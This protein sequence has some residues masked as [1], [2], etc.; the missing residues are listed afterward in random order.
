MGFREINGDYIIMMGRM[1]RLW[2]RIFRN[3]LRTPEERDAPKPEALLKEGGK[4]F[5]AANGWKSIRLIEM[6]RIKGD[7]LI[8]RDIQSAW[9]DKIV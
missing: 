7:Q 9:D 1:K 5:H 2:R 6:D 4:I 8:R 3:D